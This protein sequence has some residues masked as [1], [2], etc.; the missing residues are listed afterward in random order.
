MKS[1][2]L[3]FVI[4]NLSG[5]TECIQKYIENKLH[6]LSEDDMKQFILKNII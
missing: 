5:F 2:E 6:A 1:E 3:E 4:D